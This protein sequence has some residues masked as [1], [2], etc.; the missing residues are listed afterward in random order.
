MPLYEYECK[1]CNSAFESFQNIK[2]RATAVCPKCGTLVNM[3]IR[4]L[5]ILKT[6]TWLMSDSWA[7][8]R[9]RQSRREREHFDPTT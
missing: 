9:I 2:D 5:K 7:R 3:V 1:E 6:D 4:P 8:N